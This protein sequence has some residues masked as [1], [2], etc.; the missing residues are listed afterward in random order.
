[1]GNKRL[2][3]YLSLFISLFL[4]GISIAQ[5]P[6]EKV[7]FSRIDVNSGLSNSNITC[8]L[9][10]SYGFLWIGSR[11]GLN[12]FDGYDF[13]IYRNDQED[14]TSLLK[15]NI[16]V[17]FEDSRKQIWVS[18]RGG[19]LQVYDRKLDRFKRI[20]EFSSYCVVAHISE[21]Q[22]HNLWISGVRNDHA[23]AA[24][25]DRDTGKWKSYEIFP[26]IE[27]VTFLKHEKDNQF[28]VGV[29]R[30]GF[31]KWNLENNQVKKFTPDPKDPQSI[32][33][34]FL[35][36]VADDRGNLWMSTSEGVSRF[37]RQTEKFTNFTVANTKDHPE[38]SIILDLCYDGE[39]LW[40]GT[41]NGG[42]LRLN[43][44]KLT[45]TNFK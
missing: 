37:N 10:D 12:K 31:Y 14:S 18:T 17:L 13:K 8:F 27:P 33:N 25:L 43:T 40:L 41:E 22:H 32:S 4:C 44:R 24:Q 20:K 30:T 3:L 38:L 19:G 29:R 42:L 11:D 5:S 45:F 9:H 1:M 34:G 23:F 28:W 39:S 16:Y 15:N 7:K 35:R 6:L 2:H 36:A 26:S 21:D